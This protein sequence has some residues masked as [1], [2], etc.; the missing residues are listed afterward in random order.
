VP[1]I[2]APC[3]LGCT[4]ARPAVSDI[5]CRSEKVNPHRGAARTKKKRF[6]DPE[7]DAVI[8]ANLNG[9]TH[10]YFAVRPLRWV[11]AVLSPT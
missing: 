6:C 7:E 11:Q 4:V 3:Y 9:S 10:N 2:H 5:F 8:I 1:Q